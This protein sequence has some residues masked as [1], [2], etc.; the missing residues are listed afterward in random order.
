MFLIYWAHINLCFEGMKIISRSS[1][2]V[3]IGGGSRA[4]NGAV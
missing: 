1:G 2:T 3:G 4:D